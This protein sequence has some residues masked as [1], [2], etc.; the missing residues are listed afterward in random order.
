VCESC[1]LLIRFRCP[2]SSSNHFTNFFVFCLSWLLTL[3]ISPELV[4]PFIGTTVTLFVFGNT[5]SIIRNRSCPERL[6]FVPRV[7]NHTAS[8]GRLRTFVAICSRYICV[9]ELVL[10]S[11]LV[12][13]MNAVTPDLSPLLH[14]TLHEFP[15]RRLRIGAPF[16][17]SA[18]APCM[19]SSGTPS[20]TSPV[21]TIALRHPV[22]LVLPACQCACTLGLASEACEACAMGFVDH[23]RQLCRGLNPAQRRPPASPCCLRAPLRAC[24]QPVYTRLLCSPPMSGQRSTPAPRVSSS[25]SPSLMSY[26]TGF[27]G[28]A[29]QPCSTGC[30]TCDDGILGLGRRLSSLSR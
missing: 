28:P 4:S 26:A 25:G 24:V 12:V 9:L 20:R 16:N 3:I 2:S 27:F 29:C 18:R 6:D 5:A 13:K 15:Y 30:A 22:V 10:L 19:S 1:P 23:T 17:Q 7:T 21:P 14:S 8:G 11:Q